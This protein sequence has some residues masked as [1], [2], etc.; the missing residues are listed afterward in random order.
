MDPDATIERLVDALEHRDQEEAVA[1][2][3]DLVKWMQRGG[4]AP[5][6]EYH[7]LE[8]LLTTWADQMRHWQRNPVA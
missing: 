5:K 1:A 7:T 6:F 8:F 4:F 3:D 2:L